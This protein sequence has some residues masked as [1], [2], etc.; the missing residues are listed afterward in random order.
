MRVE[1]QERHDSSAPVVL[2][3]G[4]AGFLGQALVRELR[5]P[6]SERISRPREIRIFDRVV[7][8]DGPPGVIGIGGDVRSHEDLLEACIGVDA[9]IHAASLVDFGHASDDLLQAVNVV[10]TENVI[11]ACRD[12]GVRALVHTSTMDVIY[13]GRPVLNGDET[14]PYPERFADRY[15]QTKALGEQAALQANGAPRKARSGEDPAIARLQTCAVRP[16][17]MYGEADP[18]HISNVLRM[19]EQGKLTTRIGSGRAVFQHAYVGNV[20]HGHALALASLLSD[21]PVAAGEI[22]IIT[23]SP[24]MNFFDFMEP[25]MLRLGHDYPPRSRTLP[26]PMVFALGA[27]LEWG[28]K[29][30]RPVVDLQPLLTRS[31][32][33]IICQDFSFSGEKA[34]RELGYRPVYTEQQS[35][36]R[37]VEYFAA[38]G[39]VPAPQRVVD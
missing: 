5:D 27:L 23:D 26:Y 3:T 9:V 39:P 12:A 14:I 19:V 20:A 16:C 37:T 38:H 10:G 15:A 6:K 25:I 24:A 7:A 28:A 34:M 18:Y 30:V 13:A 11:R 31:S 8:D 4:G 32:V 17:G 21:E 35:L 29:L 22:Y 36:A 33:R 2:I 1:D